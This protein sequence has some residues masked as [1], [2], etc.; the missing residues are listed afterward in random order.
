MEL[1]FRH[2]FFGYTPDSVKQKIDLMEKEFEDAEKQ[3][4]DQLCQIESEIE[5][6]KGRICSL[7]EDISQ[8]ETAKQEISDLLMNAHM[9]ATEK[10]YKSARDA[11]QI[12]L[13]IREDV[14]K[15]EQEYERFK[16][17]LK[18]LAEEMR[19][20]TKDYHQALEASKNEQ[21]V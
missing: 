9:Q 17:T 10:V 16:N 7:V 12:S 8:H 15:R 20:L 18:R 21:D 11:E 13:D 1:V 5:L 19:S 2:S 6:L 3:L 4:N 14:L